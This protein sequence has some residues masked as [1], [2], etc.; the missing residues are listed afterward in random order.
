[1]RCPNPNC[2][3]ENASGYA[4]CEVC[5]TQL[6][7]TP[8]PVYPLRQA[9][10][11]APAPPV[12]VVQGGSDRKVPPWLWLLLG[13]IIG[14]MCLCSLLWFSILPLPDQ[15]VQVANNLPAVVDDFFGDSIGRLIVEIRDRQA[16]NP[17]WIS[18]VGSS[19][20][21]GSTG[22]GYTGGS[23]S[24]GSS[25]GSSGATF[26]PAQ[27]TNCRY[28]PSSSAFD[29]RATIYAGDTV[30][31]V[32]KGAP[33]YG[34]WWVVTVNGLQ[35]WVWSDLGTSRNA[36]GVAVISPPDFPGGEGP[37]VDEES[38]PADDEEQDE[39]EEFCPLIGVNPSLHVSPYSGE[40]EETYTILVT[41]FA[42]TIPIRITVFGPD[43]N[44]YLREEFDTVNGQARLDFYTNVSDPSGTYWV[45]YETNW[46]GEYFHDTE[47]FDHS[48]G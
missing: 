33:P 45:E 13:L 40:G 41:G 35:C 12:V 38:P 42:G 19:G 39:D 5:G 25:G 48:G 11:S 32:G 10:P 22:G 34:D 27:N 44:T 1:M 8:A 2:Q 17:P 36:G 15:A 47:S 6:T 31:I 18:G 28:G 24:A 30:I 4:Y 26:T 16:Q 46:C 7:G 3:H 37:V 9:P 29:I 21:G 14:P 20:S 43:G 23:S